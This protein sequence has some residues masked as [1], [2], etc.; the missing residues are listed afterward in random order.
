MAKT[1]KMVQFVCFLFLSE[2]TL[3]ET[4]AIQNVGN[5]VEVPNESNEDNQDTIYTSPSVGNSQFRITPISQPQ[6]PT[7][8]EPTLQPIEVSFHDFATAPEAE[9]SNHEQVATKEE[10][11]TL[12][13]HLGDDSDVIYVSVPDEVIYVPNSQEEYNQMVADNSSTQHSN[14]SYALVTVLTQP[15]IYVSG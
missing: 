6:N 3:E 9:N 14:E 11:L 13:Y 5:E 1:F 2:E 4:T 12:S 15:E 8:N 10:K 7:P